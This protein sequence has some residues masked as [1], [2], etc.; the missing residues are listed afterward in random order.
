MN[1]EILFRGKRVDNGAWVEGDLAHHKDGRRYIRCWSAETYTAAVV[2]PG[3]V[4]Q[5]TGMTDKNGTRIFEGD[6]VRGIDD[7]RLIEISSVVEYGYLG[8]G[9]SFDVYGFAFVLKDDFISYQNCER[10]E[11]I[12]N[13]HDN[14]LE[15]TK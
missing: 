14:D 12:G 1:R 11:V 4:G 7:Y 5:F 2:D 6:I 15:E 9:D 3:T 10:I 8:G 13:I